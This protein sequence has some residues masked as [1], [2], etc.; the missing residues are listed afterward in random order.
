[1]EEEISDIEMFSESV[2][3]DEL[4]DV[5]NDQIQQLEQTVE[6]YKTKASERFMNYMKI[7]IENEQ[8]KN[9]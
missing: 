9:K 5:L 8:L 3:S 7:L 6:Y 4:V 2:S 1:M